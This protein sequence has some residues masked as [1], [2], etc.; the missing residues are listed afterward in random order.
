MLVRPHSA[1]AR[2]SVAISRLTSLERDLVVARRGLAAC[3]PRNDR[4]P[5]SPGPG[6]PGR[7]T[8]ALAARRPA[9]HRAAPSQAVLVEDLLSGQQS[10]KALYALP[11]GHTHLLSN[12]INIHTVCMLSPSLRMSRVVP[13]GVAVR[14]AGHEHRVD[15]RRRLDTYRRRSWS[16]WITATSRGTAPGIATSGSRAAVSRRDPVAVGVVFKGG[17]RTLRTGSISSLGRSTT[18]RAAMAS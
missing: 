15:G 3:F 4:A 18:P 16:R 7:S 9:Y 5:A 8:A 1:N 12:L 6:S 11:D 10:P 14:S 13:T 17:T 2:R